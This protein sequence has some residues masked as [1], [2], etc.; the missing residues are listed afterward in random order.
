MEIYAEAFFLYNFL[1]D[2]FLLYTTGKILKL[3][4]NG[5][6]IVASFFG[7]WYSIFV[8]VLQYKFIGVF[9]LRFLAL[10]IMICF[11]F[12][13]ST[14]VRLKAMGVFLLVSLMFCGVLVCANCLIGG[15]VAV[16]DGY[17]VF[18]TGYSL[19]FTCM[20]ISL[21]FG[22]FGVKSLIKKFTL[23]DMHKELKITFNDKTEI[24]D[25]LV[26]TGNNV[27]DYVNK[28][29]VILINKEKAH[30]ENCSVHLIEIS[31]VNQS[32]SL[33]CLTPTK[34]EI[35]GKRYKATVGICKEK[36]AGCE[37]LIG[38]NMLVS[39]GEYV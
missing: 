33:L 39:E 26:D 12:K 10:Y 35:D 14:F 15:G 36:L 3:K 38:A 34:V 1:I 22:G 7:V 29:P 37:A 28:C 11:S 21:I 13:V 25:A 4:I 17:P 18:L 20:F 2:A 23:R 19:L 6:L 9:P 32:S 31:T 16:I 8:Q 24:F 5:G 27:Y 30:F